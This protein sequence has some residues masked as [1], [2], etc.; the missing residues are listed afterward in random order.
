MEASVIDLSAIPY[1]GPWKQASC[2]T[3]SEGP[4]KVVLKKGAAYKFRPD[5]DI[6]QIVPGELHNLF[7][8]RNDPMTRGYMI[9]YVWNTVK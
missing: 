9:R 7:T 8:C 6:H 3:Y 5:V 1:E 2:S 4:L